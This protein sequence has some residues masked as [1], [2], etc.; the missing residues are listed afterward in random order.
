MDIFLSINNRKQIIQL[1]IVPA[2]FKIPSPMNNET[3]TTINQGDIKVIG[4]RGL[5]A[6]TI[7]TFFPL[8]HYPFSRNRAY[9]GWEYVEIIE[10]WI[11]KRV[12]IRLIITNTPINLAMTIEN[13]E[14][15]PQDGSGDI[16]YSLSLSEFKF[17]NLEKKKVK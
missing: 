16:Y 14:Y 17:I 7:E 2:E 13:F 11:D 5:K 12:P 9:K 3:F 15:G 10:S 4:R 6:L 1:P 8:K